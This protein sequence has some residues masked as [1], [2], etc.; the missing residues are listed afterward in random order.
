MSPSTAGPVGAPPWPCE[1]KGQEHTRTQR[2]LRVM[3]SG[4]AG[5]ARTEKPNTLDNSCQMYDSVA[6][7]AYLASPAHASRNSR[8]AVLLYLPCRTSLIQR[9]PM[10]RYLSIQRLA[11]IDQLEIEFGPGLS[12]LTGETGAGKSIL[13]EAVGLLLGGRA[14]A[15]LVRTGADAAMV[16]A[17]IEDTRRPRDHDPP[18]DLRA[19]PQPR[20]H[21]W[22][23]RHHRR[24]CARRSP[25]SSTSTDSTSIRRC[26]LPQ[27]QLA[28]LDQFAASCRG[29]ADVD[30]NVRR[31]AVR[32]DALARRCTRKDRD[33]GRAPRPPRVPAARDRQGRAA[34]RGRRRA[35]RDQ[36]LVARQ[37]RQAQP[38][39]Q[40]KLRRPLRRRRRRS[41]RGLNAVWKRVASWP[42]LD[43]ARS[44][45]TSSARDAIRTAAR[46][47]GLR[48]AATIASNHGRVADRLQADRRSARADRASEAALRSDARRRARRSAPRSTPSSPRSTD[49]RRPR[50]GAPP[51][52][53]RRDATRT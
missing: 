44:A 31:V 47:P 27:T 32:R 24:R 36:R 4:A 39:L 12:V 37:R 50:C 35:D 10:I 29:W 16:Q 9:P 3:S 5:T 23:A 28:L 49:Q 52:A 20:L 30:R 48:A 2:D 45:R 25:I 6:V 26:S 7:R 46:G 18:R 51:R 40:R 34:R 33:R 41:W 15:D 11:I 53:R 21:R 13:V 17:V 19:G 8:H 42:T 38:P 22:R 1:R 43:P 14:T